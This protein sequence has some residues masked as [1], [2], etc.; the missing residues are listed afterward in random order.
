MTHK[1]KETARWNERRI[2]LKK[3]GKI[4]IRRGAVFQRIRYEWIRMGT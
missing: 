1:I 2:L 4:Q 3:K